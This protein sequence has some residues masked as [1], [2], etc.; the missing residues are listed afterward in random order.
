[1][2][3][4]WIGPV[5]SPTRSPNGRS[6]DLEDRDDRL[7]HHLDS[8][9]MVKQRMVQRL[10]PLL[11]EETIHLPKD[12]ISCIKL[13]SD[14]FHNNQPMIHLTA[15]GRK[16]KTQ[17]L[18]PSLQPLL[19]HRDHPHPSFMT[20]EAI[21]SSNGDDGMIWETELCYPYGS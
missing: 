1:M 3:Y 20:I 18:N 2:P 5:C 10:L 11:M 15:S 21:G 7:H 6:E 12:V 13:R 14:I 9:L 17:V 16:C 4:R 19:S 8:S